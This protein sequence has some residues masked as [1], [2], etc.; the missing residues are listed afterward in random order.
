MTLQTPQ[1]V[2]DFFDSVITTGSGFFCLAMRNGVVWDQEWYNW[3]KDKTVIVDRI[4]EVK[5]HANVY[6]SAHLFSEAKATKSNVLPSRTIQADLDHA[7]LERIPIAPT[8][9]IQTSEGRHQAYWVL[10]Q[11]LPIALLENL[12]QRL[13]YAIP[14]SDHSGWSLG[15]RVR[16]P[17]TQNF[18]YATPQSITIIKETRKRYSSDEL[19]L[20]A[21]SSSN[22]VVSLEDVEKLSETKLNIGPNELL[23]TI[24]GK[25]PQIVYLSYNR[26]VRDR[27]GALW[28]L[29]CALFRAGFDKQQV[30]WLAKNSANNKWAALRFHQ[31]YELAKDVLRAEE[32]TN[33]GLVD[34][35]ETILAQKRMMGLLM[36]QRR[37]NIADIVIKQLRKDGKFIHTQ[38]DEIWYVRG[39]IG[40]PIEIG[41][42]STYFQALCDLEFGLNSSEPEYKFVAAH[43]IASTHVMPMIGQR[44]ALSYYDRRT[45]TM[46]LHTGRKDVIK[47]TAERVETVSNGTDDII[48]PWPV[49]SDQFSPKQ[50]DGSW[51]DAMFSGTL[52]NV[53]NISSEQA[54]AILHVWFLFVLFRDLAPSRPLLG[55]LGQP[56]SGKSTIFNKFYALIYGEGRK[57]GAVTTSDE[58]DQAVISDPLTVM[59]G[60]DT[61]LSWL[62]DRLSLS[63]ASRDISRRKLYTDTETIV[64]RRQAMVGITAHNPRFIREDIADRMLIINFQRLDAFIHESQIIN[65]V[66]DQRDNLWGSVILE[67]QKVLQTPMPQTHEAPHF[68]IE[69][70]AFLGL[71]MA[72]GVGVEDDFVSAIKHI[73]ED[74]SALVIEEDQMLIEV[75]QRLLEKHGDSSWHTATDLWRTLSARAS[76]PQAFTRRYKNARDLAAKLFAMNEALKTM[77]NIE[78]RFDSNIN[79]RVW[80]FGAKE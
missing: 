6:F 78:W 49:T 75:L 80:K 33:A 40:R 15:H 14:N 30:F 63:A 73:K 62:P 64:R 71:W 42:R 37:Q 51:A 56:G 25:L 32:A 34:I 35:K 13:T 24:K 50:P 20:L 29:M 48:F 41:P 74:Q 76:D 46:Y 68:R 8:Y 57:I 66:L 1:T 44:R 22:R 38:E 45:K 31:D 3:P 28:A 16:V 36:T 19:E 11:E 72:R 26:L 52:N 77:F 70:F 43:I 67:I 54:R 18:K 58:Y 17:Y 9:T 7:E 55:L 53:I 69:D 59:D 21:P 61:Y 2:G 12:S 60:A 47:I 65:T 27:S 39:D 79:A 23:E 10:D 5:D 4:D